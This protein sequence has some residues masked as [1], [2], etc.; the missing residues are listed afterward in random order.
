MRKSANAAFMP[1]QNL[2]FNQDCGAVRKGES[3]Q[4]VA[5]TDKG[6]IVESAR[7]VSMVALRQLNRVTICRKRDMALA[8]GDRLQL[9]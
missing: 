5:I 9:K 3:A 7:K 4:L 1:P 6:L 2:V 8:A